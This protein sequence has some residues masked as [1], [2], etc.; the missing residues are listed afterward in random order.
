MVTLLLLMTINMILKAYYLE[1]RE[2]IRASKYFD[3]KGLLSEMIAY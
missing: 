1:A 3:G 2:R